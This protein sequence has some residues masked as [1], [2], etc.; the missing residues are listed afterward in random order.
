MSAFR[1]RTTI[2]KP[3]KTCRERTS[4]LA[5]FDPHRHL[6]EP[7]QKRTRQPGWL[8]LRDDLPVARDDLAD[9]RRQLDFRQS[10]ADAAVDAVTECQVSPGI[11][12]RHVELLGIG[13]HALV[14]VGRDVPHHHLFA[15]GDVLAAQ[16]AIDR[17]CDACG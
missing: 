10:R 1:E 13:E 4:S 14:A 9:Q 2:R 15:L 7:V 3:L 5:L 8:A 12:P 17:R 11:T 16:L 6:G